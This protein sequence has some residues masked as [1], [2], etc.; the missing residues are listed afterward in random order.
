MH[1]FDMGSEHLAPG[2][3][4]NYYYAVQLQLV[5]GLLYWIGAVTN[6]Q[7]GLGNARL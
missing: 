2:D 3:Y 6:C 5:A 7:L 4:P 1:V